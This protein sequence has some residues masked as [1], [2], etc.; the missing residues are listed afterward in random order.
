[1]TGTARARAAAG[2]LALAALAA[3]P[4]AV[5]HAVLVRSSP[6]SRAA[7][8]QPPDRVSLWFSE[9]LEPA[10]SALSVWDARGA[11]VDLRDAAPDPADRRRLG[12]SLPPLGPGQYTV[13]YR[14]LSVDG[15]VVEG[16]FAFSVRGP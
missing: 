15:H 16:R 8:L 11:Q 12:V 10:Y 14:V 9:R 6:A 5:A 2:L 13:R 1:V 4:A 3:A 7:L